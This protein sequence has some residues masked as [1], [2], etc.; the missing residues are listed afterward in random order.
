VSAFINERD[1]VADLMKADLMHASNVYL[2]TQT[3]IDS[4]KAIC[5]EED[6][7]SLWYYKG[8]FV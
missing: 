1:G 8:S 3:G 5:S 4:T 6:C 2:G 7:G